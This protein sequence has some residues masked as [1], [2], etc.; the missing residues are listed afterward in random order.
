M[1][2]SRD[3]FFTEKKLFGFHEDTGGEN[4]HLPTKNVVRGF[5]ACDLQI[6]SSF[7]KVCGRSGVKVN[8]EPLT[9]RSKLLPE[10]RREKRWFFFK[11][12]WQEEMMWKKIETYLLLK[13]GEGI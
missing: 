7:S 3:F 5:T 13:N 10:K 4:H 1:F 6:S 12:K 9:M 11:R 8:T 2:V